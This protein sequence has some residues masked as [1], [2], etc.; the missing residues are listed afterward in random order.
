MVVLFT[1]NGVWKALRDG[2]NRIEDWLPRGFQESLELEWFR[3][4]FGGDSFLM[5][6]WQG[7]EIAPNANAESTTSRF[8]DLLR[9]SGVEA[10]QPA[11]FSQVFTGDDA[12]RMLAKQAVGIDRQEAIKRLGGWMIGRDGK[13]S[14]IVTVLSDA[15]LQH[16]RAAIEAVYEAAAQTGDAALLSTENLHV[17]GPAIEAL[18][19]ERSSHRFL[20]PL[21]LA[22]YAVCAILMLFTFRSRAV[23][24]LVLA[25]AIAS[26]LL[27]LAVVGYS[28]WCRLDSIMLIAPSLIFVLSVSAAVHLVNY[29]RDAVLAVGLERAAWEATR[30]AAAPTLFASL[31]T[32]VGLLSLTVSMLVPIRN[33]GIY[34]AVGV[35]LSLGLS[36]T[37]PWQL[38]ALVP[39]GWASQPSSQGWWMPRSD[40]V[41]QGVVRYRWLI[42]SVGWIVFMMGSWGVTQLQA[43]IRIHDFF[44]PK[45]KLVEDYAWLQQTIGPLAPIEIVAKIPQVAS[46]TLLD[47]LRAVERIQQTVAADT[48]IHATAS[49]VN[50]APPLQSFKRTSLRGVAHRTLLNERMADIHQDF[51]DAG[52]LRMTLDQYLWRISARV[53][54]SDEVDY[55]RLIGN[56]KSELATLTQL[57]AE[58]GLSGVEFTITGGVPVM[59]KAQ[60]QMLDDLINSFLC[61]TVLIT[62][63]MICLFTAWAVVE[64]GFWS[65][66][67]RCWSAC[68]L[69]GLLAMIPNLLPVVVVFGAI[70]M[71][72]VTV[73]V[74][75][76]LTA[77]VAMGIAV[78][79]T[80]HFLTWY[81]RSRRMCNSRQDSVVFALTRCA[82]A[83]SQTTA[84]FVFGLAVFTLSPYL[85]TARYAGIMC[86]MLS[87][88]LVADLIV[89]PALLLSPVGRVFDLG[90]ERRAVSDTQRP[91]IC[92]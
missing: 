8:A 75:S 91:E 74:G 51:I 14:C 13:S 68:V 34:S 61:S 5:I 26:Q 58:D 84:I 31:T 11:F 89:L 87:I 35:L 72:G 62:C 37:L 39:A 77:T 70:G 47:Q 88:A 41:V 53:F 12:L 90:H 7:C 32:A 56:L 82:R 1:L 16:D 71:M 69:S 86:S 23:T 25:N 50:F 43:M 78:D 28:P 80:L 85:P 24:C 9:K 44:L 45:S 6:S 76:M 52:F 42:L 54:S 15:G 79:D 55:A 46:P 81:H 65:R 33:F 67:L 21:N 10:G 92:P 17:A 18:E 57:F 19:I 20:L 83:M 60:D 2:S 40:K 66:P 64:P 48:S 30:S 29:Y 38:R 3:S 27:L 73:G 22:C 4:Q 36:A 59:Q 63:S 49:A